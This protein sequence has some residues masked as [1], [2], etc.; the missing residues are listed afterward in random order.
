MLSKHLD[1]DNLHHA[2][3]I[4][5]IKDQVIPEILEIIQSFGIQTLGNA[6]FCQISID[7][8]KIEEALNLRSMGGEKGVS[9]GKKIF[10]VSANSISLDAQAVLLKMF[11]E[12]TSGTHFFLVVPDKNALLDTLVSRFYL[13]SSTSE[14]GG[15]KEVEEFI[16]MTPSARIIFLKD[17]LTEE[18]NEDEVAM[19]SIRAKSLRFL[20][21][22][23]SVLHQK[24]FKPQKNSDGL[25]L[26]RVPSGIYAVQS[27]SVACFTQIFKVRKFLRQPGSSTKSLMESI[28]LVMPNF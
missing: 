21:A 2:Y 18:E 13:I 5:G 25:T 19:D 10:I 23:E 20:N 11:E 27:F 1:K 3:L 4:E 26:P 28:A 14:R 17:F 22:L 6:D 16:K 15:T 24:T 7:S 9:S 8:F 12:P